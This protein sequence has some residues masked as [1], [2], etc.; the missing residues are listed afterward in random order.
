M[1][2]R[3]IVLKNLEGS[4]KEDIRGYIQDTVDTHEE[5]ALP[6]M[7][8]LL[9]AAWKVSDDKTKDMIMDTIMKAL[10]S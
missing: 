8:I 1:D 5:K 3:K 6:G 9:E 4:S 2:I 7:G 10:Q